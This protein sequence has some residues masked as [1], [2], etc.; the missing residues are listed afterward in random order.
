MIFVSMTSDELLARTA[1]Y[2]IQHPTH[3]SRSRRS[4]RR[5]ALLSQ[6]YANTFRPPL[7]SLGR[8][9]L[10][11]PEEYSDSE[12]EPGTLA[13][14]RP[15]LAEL[16]GSTSGG[17]TP[18]FRVTT[19]FDDK[20]DD[21]DS[22]DDHP[23]NDDDFPAVDIERM[24]FEQ[25]EEELFC[26]DDEESNSDNDHNGMSF[27]R[28]LESRRR[29]RGARQLDNLDDN[30]LRRRRNPGLIEPIASTILGNS[31]HTGSSRVPEVLKPHACFFIEREKSMVSIKFDPP[32]YV[33]LSLD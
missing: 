18:E 14:I 9:A 11:G 20:S 22:D 21:D 4:R 16:V 28:H 33:S 19:D 8:V 27:R 32:P 30:D 17:S 13:A 23:E 29:M 6:E 5:G 24:D 2:Q 7:Q 12:M 3:H 10:T 26:P 1:Q 25:L 15:G 31:N